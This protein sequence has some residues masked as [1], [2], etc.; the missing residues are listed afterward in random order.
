M[1][2]KMMSQRTLISEN[3]STTDNNIDCLTKITHKP[4]SSSI[5]TG[6]GFRIKKNIDRASQKLI[7]SFLEFNTPDIS[8][9]L[10]R[11]YTMNSQIQDLT[12]QGKIIGSAC[13]V[14]VYP[15]DN[16]MVHKALDI[17][18]SGDIIVVDCG[19]SCN[20]IIGDLIA[21]KAKHRGIAGF[22]IDGLIRD[23]EGIREIGMPVYAKG[24]TPKGP[25]HRGPGEINY[26]IVCGGIVVNPGDIIY[27]DANGIVTI[28]QE[29]ANELLRMLIESRDRLENYIANVKLGKFSN[30]WVDNTLNANNCLYI[31]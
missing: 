5:Y 8:D 27:G 22:V 17:A 29:F 16:L 7:E 1:Y 6:P 21:T 9:M 10:N 23:V 18:K 4:T 31:D 25:L 12:G 14:K 2:L 20:G 3:G 15:G 28:H 24:N 30:D 19:E 13:T 26:P 11:M